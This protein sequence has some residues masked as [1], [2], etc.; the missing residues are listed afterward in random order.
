MENGA[1]IL[2]EMEAFVWHESN[3]QALIDEWDTLADEVLLNA[4]VRYWDDMEAVDLSDAVERAKKLL[5]EFGILK[6][7]S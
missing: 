1:N 2:A 5:E 6:Y 4:Q 7:S 3:N